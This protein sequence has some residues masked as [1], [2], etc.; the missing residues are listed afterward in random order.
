MTDE[1][2]NE[3]MAT[4]D[5]GYRGHTVRPN[6]PKDRTAVNRTLDTFTPEETDRYFD[7]LNDETHSSMEFPKQLYG[8]VMGASLSKKIKCALTVKKMWT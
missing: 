4:L 8:N 7:L 3:S 5:S 1:L 2:I 6:Y